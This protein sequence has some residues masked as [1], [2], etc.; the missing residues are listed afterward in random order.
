MLRDR[1]PAVLTE[2]RTRPLFTMKLDVRPIID[3]G[4]TPSALRRIGVIYGGRFEG[5]RLSGT[6]LDG[7]S[8]W[9]SMR[10]DKTTHL[11]VRINLKT[12]DGALINMTY[13]GL[14]HG[15]AE[16]MAR[17]A[18]GEEVDPTSY[19]F[20]MTA[21]FETAAESYAYLNKLCAI[22]LGHRFADGPIYNVLELL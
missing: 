21:T 14:R 18:K 3:I 8:D 22:G 1:L 4:Q 5:E 13:E 9:Q 6:I 16:I 11:D 10:T 20:R 15:P 12:D 17:I 7:G 2:V 19:Y